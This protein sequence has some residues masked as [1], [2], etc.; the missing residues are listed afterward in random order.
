MQVFWCDVYW[1]IWKVFYILCMDNIY[2]AY[3]HLRQ[4]HGVFRSKYL[5]DF[6]THVLE[7][8]QSL[9]EEHSIQTELGSSGIL[10]IQYI[11]I[12]SIDFTFEP[13]RLVFIAGNSVICLFS[14]H[15]MRWAIVLFWSKRKLP[16]CFPK[17]NVVAKAMENKPQSY[18]CRLHLNIHEV[19][20]DGWFLSSKETCYL[21]L[22]Q[23]RYTHVQTVE[24][25]HFCS[26][27]SN[28]WCGVP[29]PL[30]CVQNLHK[31]SRLHI[32]V[33]C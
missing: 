26:L 16:G 24:Y 25:L 18:P 4:C 19:Q 33:H 27:H 17:T 3:V 28:G 8:Y 31:L 10:Q 12:L 11:C 21:G 30:P 5:V 20:F 29:V 15:W 1:N 7:W 13:V 14:R 22:S 6:Y 23:C 2:M 32:K 9:Q